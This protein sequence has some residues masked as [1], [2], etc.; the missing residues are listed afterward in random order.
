MARLLYLVALAAWLAAS[1]PSGAFTV[2]AG[3]G[4]VAIQESSEGTEFVLT[5]KKGTELGRGNA[6]SFGSLIFRDLAAGRARLPAPRR[7]APA[8]RPKWRSS[9]SRTTRRRSS[10]PRRR[11]SRASSTSRRATGRS[12]P[13]WC[14]RRSAQTLADGPFPT[15]VEYSGYDPANPDARSPSTLIAQ[16]LGF[17]T[18]GV[19]MRG[20]GCSG[21]VIDLFDLPTTAD[22]YDII[23]TVAAQS[24]VKGGKVGMV[25]I[26]FPGIS[27]VFVGGARPPH[28]EALAPLSVIADIY[29][30]PGL[31]GGIFN[32]GFAQSWLQEPRGRR[33]ARARTAAR[34]GRSSA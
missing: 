26:S 15:V 14:A 5:D 17:A 25:G 24:W 11:S 3:I 2:Q 29:R 22:G 28:L 18:V 31:P 20:S 34:A 4:F 6:D 30:A 19:N 8:R 9:A 7:A 12:S 33:A 32:N 23:E 27:Q 21:G 16:A 10:T 1:A 13:R